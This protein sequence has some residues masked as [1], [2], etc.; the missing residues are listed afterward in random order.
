VKLD[1]IAGSPERLF[2]GNDMLRRRFAAYNARHV[3]SSTPGVSDRGF[4]VT[5][6]VL[7]QR[8]ILSPSEFACLAG[9]IHE[10]REK[11][12]FLL[13]HLNPVKAGLASCPED[14]PWSSVHDDT[15]TID[16]A[17]ATP[18]GLSVDRVKNE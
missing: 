13:I 8:R 5:C 18:S 11:H 4:F 15:G 16:H 9:A 1:P 14:W 7:P 17:P 10:R 12:G 2:W 3:A 6:R